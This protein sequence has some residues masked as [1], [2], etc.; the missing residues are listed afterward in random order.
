M[1]SAA[2]AAFAVVQHRKLSRCDRALRFGETN[3]ERASLVDGRMAGLIC[4]AIA[5]LD[6]RIEFGRA[7][8]HQPVAG[9]RGQRTTYEQRVIVP[10]HGEQF[11]AGKV[12]GRHVPGVL[13]LPARPP[14]SRPPRCPSV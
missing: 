13:A 5:H 1:T 14:I 3:L 9:P 7:G 11:V 2:Q 8:L 12:L 4:L 6:L 10:L